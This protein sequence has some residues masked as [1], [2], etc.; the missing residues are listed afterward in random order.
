MADKTWQ[1]TLADIRDEIT[2][3]KRKSFRNAIKKV[4]DGNTKF[5]HDRRQVFMKI[6]SEST[7][8]ISNESQLDEEFD[9][10]L[11]LIIEDDDDNTNQ[12]KKSMGIL[13]SNYMN[14][15]ASRNVDIRALIL[16]VAALNLVD[17]SDGNDVLIQTARRLTSNALRIK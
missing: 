16:L 3:K 10:I 11:N 14:T 8:L 17:M 1:Q 2:P 7:N 15:L 6:L 12:S 4:F 13:I 5:D 9:E